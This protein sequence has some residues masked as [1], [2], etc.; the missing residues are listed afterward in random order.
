MAGGTEIVIA[1][2]E[3]AKLSEAL[4]AIHR[5]GFGHLT[6]VLDP[7]RGEVIGQLRRAGVDVPAGFALD[8]G[9]GVAIM[10]SAAA[11]ASAAADL[12]RRFDAGS[13]WT[14]EKS[15]ASQPLPFGS[16]AP[17]SRS[18]RGP[19]SESLAD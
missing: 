19:L 12:L 16:L 6:R 10:I 11:R 7:E 3:R 13:I 14:A 9:N 2:I 1:T 4:T 8:R 18:R 17:R 5:G 15:A